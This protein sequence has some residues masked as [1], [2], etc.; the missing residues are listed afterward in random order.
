MD[1]SFANGKNAGQYS[2]WGQF[3]A[4]LEVLGALLEVVVERDQNIPRRC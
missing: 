2:P 3:P 1:L 4:V